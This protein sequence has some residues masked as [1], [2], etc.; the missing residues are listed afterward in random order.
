MPKR[1]FVKNTGRTI[2]HLNA[3]YGT[4]CLPVRGSSPHRQAPLAPH[5]VL[6]P[7]VPAGEFHEATANGLLSTILI[8]IE[9]SRPEAMPGR[10][11]HRGNVT[12]ASSGRVDGPAAC[13]ARRGPDFPRATALPASGRPTVFRKL[14]RP[15]ITDQTHIMTVIRDHNQDR[16]V[17]GRQ[18]IA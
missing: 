12:P 15:I 9:K 14:Q 8:L 1:P 2:L 13:R 10:V 7:I 4:L 3:L 16:G 6:W 11:P 5:A 17:P 18:R